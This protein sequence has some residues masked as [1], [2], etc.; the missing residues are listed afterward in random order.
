M[1]FADNERGITLRYAHEIDD[2]TLIFKDSYVTGI[3]RPTCTNC[4]GDNKISYCAG[5]YGVRMFTAT[6]T[7]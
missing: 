5:G 4:Y 2:N 3:S 7:G 6:I 1:F